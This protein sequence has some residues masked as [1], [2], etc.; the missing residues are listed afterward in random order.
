MVDEDPYQLPSIDESKWFVGGHL[1]SQIQSCNWQVGGR[2][3][4]G[5]GGG[6]P[7]G[8]GCLIVLSSHVAPCRLGGPTWNERPTIPH[9]ASHTLACPHTH[10]DPLQVVNATTPAN[11]F[12]VLRRQLHRQFRKPLVMMAPKNLLRH[13]AAKSPLSDFSESSTDKEIQG[14]LRRACRRPRAHAAPLPCPP[15]HRPFPPPPCLYR[16]LCTAPV[17]QAT[18]SSA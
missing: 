15:R 16:T 7:G 14:G 11:Y 4:G 18:A 17:P 5:G 10:A 12:H 3:R 2:G 6:G 13:P 8:A 1:G 9:T